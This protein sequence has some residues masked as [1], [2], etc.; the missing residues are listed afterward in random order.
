MIIQF[1]IFKF[2]LPFI[3]YVIVGAKIHFILLIIKNSHYPFCFFI[4]D[5]Q[6][7][8]SV[9]ADLR[10]LTYLYKITR[11]KK[12]KLVVPFY[13]F[14]KTVSELMLEKHDRLLTERNFR[15]SDTT[16]SYYLSNKFIYGVYKRYLYFVNT[17]TSL[18]CEL[19]EEEGNKTSNKSIKKY[20][21]S[22]K[23]I[24]SSRFSTDAYSGTLIKKKY[25]PEKE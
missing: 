1:S 7:P 21:L 3:I 8:E 2:K 11:N 25:Y 24:Y 5:D 9:N 15:R 20:Y 12:K 23:K 18:R 6:R 13:D 19:V 10:E 17:F 22:F 4:S 16:L 14:E